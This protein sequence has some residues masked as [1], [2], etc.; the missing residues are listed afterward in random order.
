M[1]KILKLYLYR[2]I[3]SV[4]I[5]KSKFFWIIVVIILCSGSILFGIETHLGYTRKNPPPSGYW[6]SNVPGCYNPWTD[7]IQK[8]LLSF[9]ASNEEITEKKNIQMLPEGWLPG[10]R[11]SKDT[12]PAGS[13]EFVDL[14]TLNQKLTGNNWVHGNDHIYPENT[15]VQQFTGAGVFSYVRSNEDQY[16]FND[17]AGYRGIAIEVSNL[18]DTYIVLSSKMNSW[19][20]TKDATALIGLEPGETDIIYH[21][22]LRDESHVAPEIQAYFG[23]T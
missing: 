22:F 15:W 10:D 5:V 3:K 21:P 23:V 19:W 2:T 6:Y 16:R 7:D 17:L 1:K 18:G 14:G 11:W 20:D 8:S 13:W 4:T 9:P 12:Y